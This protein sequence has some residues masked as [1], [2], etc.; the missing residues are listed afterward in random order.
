[1]W[2]MVW[3]VLSFCIYLYIEKIFHLLLMPLET[4]VITTHVME[5]FTMTLKIILMGGFILSLPF[6]FYQL[7]RFI[8]PGLYERERFFWRSLLVLSIFLFF[9]GLIFAHML[10]LPLALTFLK[11]FSGESLNSKF[12]P[13]LNAY[14]GFYINLLFAFAL[15]F[16]FPVLL[17]VLG[18]MQIIDVSFLQ[19][20]R[21]IAIVAIFIFAAIITPPDIISQI[22]LAIPM[23]GFYEIVILLLKRITLPKV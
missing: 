18:K 23:V 11:S 13:S 3:V 6:A 14:M 5:G 7:W 1:M 22:S 15:S 19:K 2:L 16:Q 9:V 21:R 8:T 12:L 20:G 4:G 17:L 10:I